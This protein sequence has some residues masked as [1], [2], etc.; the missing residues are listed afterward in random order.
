MRPANV[1]EFR[2]VKNGRAGLR[3]YVHPHGLHQEVL[4]WV[5]QSRASGVAPVVMECDARR[6]EAMEAPVPS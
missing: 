3:K 4:G 1:H 6:L 2:H 5:S